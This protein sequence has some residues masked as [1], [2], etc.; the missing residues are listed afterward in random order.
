M[1]FRETLPTLLRQYVDSGKAFLVF[2]HLPLDSIHGLAISA[3][4]ATEC[5][6]DPAHF[7]TIHD[8]LFANQTRWKSDKATLIQVLGGAGLTESAFVKCQAD[9]RTI[10]KI[11]RDRKS[12]R[13]LGISG[14]PTFLVGR[15]VGA[16]AVKVTARFSDAQPL[17]VFADAIKTAAI[18][19]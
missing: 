9:P 5:V 12:A 17:S 11:E 19:R 14:T 1:F 18:V 2:R 16:N 10:S 13:Q 3:A 4:V 7:W 8:A 6:E 15:P